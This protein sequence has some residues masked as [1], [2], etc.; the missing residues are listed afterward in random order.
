M[1][2]CTKNPQLLFC[3]NSPLELLLKY[4][5]KRRYGGVTALML[6]FSSPRFR[7]CDL[8]SDNFKKVLGSEK[9]MLDLNAYTPLMYLCKNNS[10]ML[11]RNL[12][13]MEDLFEYIILRNDYNHC[14][15]DYYPEKDKNNHKSKGY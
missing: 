14:A 7:D 15:M 12:Y 9:W 3:D 6:L 10:S 8:A 13:F 1:H 4:A 11:N 5:G 2:V